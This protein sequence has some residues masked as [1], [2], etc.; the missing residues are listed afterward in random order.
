MKQRG[1]TET[2][3]EEEGQSGLLK[4]LPLT[5]LVRLRRVSGNGAGEPELHERKAGWLK[6]K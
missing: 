3:E 5:G 2:R 1:R 6:D 4:A